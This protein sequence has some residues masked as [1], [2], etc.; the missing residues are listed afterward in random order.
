M[1]DFCARVLIG[2]QRTG[3]IGASR[4]DAWLNKILL[5]D[6]K[7]VLRFWSIIDDVPKREDKTKDQYNIE[8]KAWLY[9]YFESNGQNTARISHWQK[10]VPV[11]VKEKKQR[12]KK[13]IKVVIDYKDYP[14]YLEKKEELKDYEIAQEKTKIIEVF[15]KKFNFNFSNIYPLYAFTLPE[16]KKFISEFKGELPL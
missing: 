10:I 13:K 12:G 5:S 16:L 6:I 7:F 14:S 2:G 3:G 8:R 9:D 11:V 1:G 4:D 15:R